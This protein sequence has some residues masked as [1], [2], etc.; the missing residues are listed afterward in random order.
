MHICKGLIILLQIPLVKNHDAAGPTGDVSTIG[1]MYKLAHTL[2]DEV[3]RWA[4]EAWSSVVAPHLSIV[5]CKST[6]KAFLAKS[7]KAVVFTCK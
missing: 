1:N 7:L 6:M 4:K 5:E 2:H 3:L